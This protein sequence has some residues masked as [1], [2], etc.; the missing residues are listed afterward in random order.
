MSFGPGD[1]LFNKLGQ[2]VRTPEALPLTIDDAAR[3]P[4]ITV[5]MAI[6]ANILTDIRER[7]VLKVC[8]F[9]VDDQAPPW[10]VERSDIDTVR[11]FPVAVA[12]ALV[13]RLKTRE[14]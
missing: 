14:R 3:K 8:V 10:V 2:F 9:E 5:G 13:P 1:E 4:V 7:H 11:V 6:C 12:L